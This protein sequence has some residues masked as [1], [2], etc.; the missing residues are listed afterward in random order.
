MTLVLSQLFPVF[1]WQKAFYEKFRG[2]AAFMGFEQDY[3]MF[4]PE[5]RHEN[6]HLIAIVTHQDGTLEIWRYPRMEEL[7]LIA[8]IFKERF[9]KFG[10]DNIVD[11]RFGT[12]LPDLARFI[13]RRTA[14]FSNP[15][16]SVSIICV[17]DEIPP[18]AIDTADRLPNRASETALIDYDVEPPDLK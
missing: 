13:A 17:S 2:W 12:L 18:P 10:Y 8:R 5:P 11:P 14:L 16:R 4:A 15:P 9:R 6:L 3:S 7:D 1:P